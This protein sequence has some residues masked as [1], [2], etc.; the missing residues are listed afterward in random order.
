M[1]VRS[2]KRKQMKK[3]KI[4]NLLKGKY[5]CDIIFSLGFLFLAAVFYNGFLELNE[6]PKG[7]HQWKQSMHF[8]IIQNYLDGSVNFW[9]PAMNNLFN[10]DNTGKLILEFPIFHKI[11]ASI[12]AVFPW[13]SPSLFRWIMFIL[14]FIGFYHAYKLANLVIKNELLA[15]LTSLLVFAIPVV[16]FY[17]ANYLVDVPAMAF[18]FSA[19][20]FAERN[21]ER[22]SFVNSILCILF[23]TL[24]GLLRLPVL[25]LPMSYIGTRI[26][27]RKKLIQLLWLLPS[28]L[29]IAIWYYYVKKYNTYFVSYPPTETYGYLSPER[30]SSTIHSMLNFIVYQLGWS[31]RFILFYV[32][33]SLYLIFNWK[34][35]SRFWFLVLAFSIVGSALYIYLWF[36]IFEHH[37]YYLFPVI[38]LLFLIWV[39]VFIVSLKTDYRK[40]VFYVTL[41]ILAINA[42]NTFDNMR[43]R[44][45][46]KNIKIAHVFTGRYE[47]GNWWYF[48]NED[49]VKWRVLRDISP[50]KGSNVLEAH[51]VFST[52]TVICD[53]DPSPTYSLALL[54]LKGWTLY[55][56][57]FNS[58]DDYIKYT[59]LGAKY[60]VTSSTK[61]SSLDSTSLNILKRNIVFSVDSLVV[62]DI[63]D[64]R[65]YEPNK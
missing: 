48:G 40:Y 56:C 10:T 53:F 26:L 61:A 22:W 15:V 62:Y 41:A 42:I 20:Y 14:T 23:L 59:K 7:M 54:N 31:Y 12:V 35:V 34:K 18:G 49:K 36:G 51:G 30:L 37:D 21:I 38:P 25:I 6:L 5:C 32:L 52:D 65:P 4:E 11:T 3:I 9:H 45:Y 58:L 33:V 28:I 27:F 13:L 50:Y 64:L 46:H 8:S 1:F 2:I 24:S 29:I 57:S 55:N 60:L 19:I 44:T 47:S 16:A 17:G 39:N 63:R 43:L